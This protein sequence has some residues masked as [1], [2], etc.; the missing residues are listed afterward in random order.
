MC[1]FTVSPGGFSICFIY[2]LP[3]CVVCWHE[4]LFFSAIRIYIYT[5]EE[6]IV[7]INPTF[8]ITCHHNKLVFGWLP[9]VIGEV[10]VLDHIVVM[11][12]IISI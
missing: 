12:P 4:L 2:R 1:S 7:H 8:K 5:S 3:L 9:T 6:F 10:R 11:S